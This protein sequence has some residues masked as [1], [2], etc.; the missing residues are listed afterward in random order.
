M[1]RIAAGDLRSVR[2]GADCIIDDVTD[3]ALCILVLRIPNRREA[4]RRRRGGGA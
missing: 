1:S 2:V 4:D 3:R